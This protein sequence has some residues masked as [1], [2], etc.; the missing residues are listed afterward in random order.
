PKLRCCHQRV[1]GLLRAGHGGLGRRIVAPGAAGR[2]AR[3]HHL[4]S[5]H[6]RARLF[7]L[8]GGDQAGTAGSIQR[9]QPLGSHYR[10]RNGST[11]APRWRHRRLRVV[12]EDG[13]QSL[14]AADDWW[15]IALGSRLRWAIDQMGPHTAARIKTDNVNWLIENKIY[16][17]ETNAIY[18]IG[19]KPS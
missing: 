5:A 19:R 18:A 8:A 13:F 1:L 17:L 4:G 7:A 6:F 16:R 10:R 12:A 2:E 15:T 3:G 9:I 14:R 11:F